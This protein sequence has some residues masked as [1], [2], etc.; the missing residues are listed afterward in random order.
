MTKR[1]VTFE[2]GVNEDEGG[3]DIKSRRFKE[4]HSLDSDE[5][6]EQT[7]EMGETTTARSLNKQDK[8]GGDENVLHD[9]DIEGQEDETIREDDGIKLTPFNLKEEMEE[10]HFDAQGNYIAN[11]RDEDITDGWLDSVDWNKVTTSKRNLPNM[12]VDEEPMVKSNPVKLKK[13]MVEIMKPGENVLKALKRLGGK[14]KP[15]STADRW[16]KKKNKEEEKLS[17]KEKEQKEMLLKLTGLADVLM[18]EGDFQIYEKTFEKLNFEIKESE[19]K[20]GEDQFADA[21]VDDEDDALEAAFK[22]ESTEKSY[23]DSAKTQEKESEPKVNIS[24]EVQWFY[25]EKDDEKNEL[26][27]PFPSSQ[28]LK[29]QEEGK[30]GDGVYC[31][32]ENQEGS[33]YNSRRI[34]FDLYT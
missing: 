25:K 15:M 26:K 1:K 16:R 28:M 22:G 27:G 33:L 12:E 29:W 34:D 18:S 21:E 24:D 5:E 7:I 19:K 9:D 23:A 31:R 17:E 4:N 11:K 10:G 6:D 2:E 14:K 8:D 3:P 20:A 30:F 13:E 32:R